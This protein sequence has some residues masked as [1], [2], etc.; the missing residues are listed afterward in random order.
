MAVAQFN[1]MCQKFHHAHIVCR[2]NIWK[3][4]AVSSTFMFVVSMH[5]Y[6]LSVVI[7]ELKVT[8]CLLPSENR[9]TMQF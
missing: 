6:V 2:S 3:N 1:E 5:D 7:L 4:K 9:Q 8:H